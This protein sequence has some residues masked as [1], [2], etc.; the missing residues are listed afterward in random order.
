MHIKY[1]DLGLRKLHFFVCII[2]SFKILKL[3]VIY[4][5]KGKVTGTEEIDLCH[6]YD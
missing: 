5:F 1:F 3:V 4:Y 2:S 6:G